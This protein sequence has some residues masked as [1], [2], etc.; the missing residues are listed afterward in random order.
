MSDQI[1]EIGPVRVKQIAG[2]NISGRPAGN[3]YG[4]RTYRPVAALAPTTSVRS[5]IVWALRAAISSGILP[6]G[7]KLSDAQLCQEFSASRTSVRE[8]L[9]YLESERLI[10]ILRNGRPMVSRLS[11]IQAAT[12]YRLLGVL[13]GDA[14]FALAITIKY[15]DLQLLRACHAEIRQASGATDVEACIV[16]IDEFYNLILRCCDNAIHTDMIQNLLARIGYLR[17]RSLTNVPRAVA[18]AREVDAILSA[19]EARN[20]E[21]A[22]IAGTVHFNS[23]AEAGLK[24]LGELEL[25]IKSCR[26]PL[27]LSKQ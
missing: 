25:K 1:Q 5:R 9:R 23:E 24:I 14:M 4:P 3:P 16:H 11:G 22:R 10:S 15:R 20:S 7:E 17:A 21:R 2:Q 27:G 13:T 6:P 12:I 18:S 26:S 8:A 19:L